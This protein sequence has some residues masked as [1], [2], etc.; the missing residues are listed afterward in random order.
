MPKNI[1]TNTQNSKEHLRLNIQIAETKEEIEHLESISN[2]LD[3][4][5]QDSDLTAIKRELSDCGYIK[6]HHEK[7][8]GSKNTGKSKPLHYISSDGFDMFVGKKQLPE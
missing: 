5:R 3:I 2:S 1:L 4:A 8:K 6:K 7:N